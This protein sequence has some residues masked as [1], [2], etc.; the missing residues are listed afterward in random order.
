MKVRIYK[1]KDGKVDVYIARTRPG[2]L[3]N[4]ATLNVAAEELPAKLGRL[5]QEMRREV[6]V[7]G[8]PA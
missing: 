4:R 5:V 3:V 6:D 8:E 7:A 1:K 2:E